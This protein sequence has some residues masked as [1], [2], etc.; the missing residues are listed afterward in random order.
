[1]AVKKGSRGPAGAAGAGLPDPTAL[2]D[3]HVATVASGAWTAAAPAGIDTSWQPAPDTGWTAGGAGTAAISGGVVTLTMGAAQGDARLQRPADTSPHAPALEV[4]ARVTRIASPG[5]DFHWFGISL[6]SDSSSAGY[7]LFAGSGGLAHAVSDSSTIGTVALP[8]TVDSG[9]LWLRIVA[10][11]Y[12]VAWYAG[13]GATRPAT[14]TLVASAAAPIATVAG[15]ILTRVA[16]RAGR[17]T[18]T[19]TAEGQVADIQWRSLLG[20]PT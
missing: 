7:L 12:M 9:Q 13:A 11:P 20:A 2:P 14:W 15:N 5:A 6:A 3:G 4:V 18:G 10:T 1:M 17:A 19:G 8:A 16:A